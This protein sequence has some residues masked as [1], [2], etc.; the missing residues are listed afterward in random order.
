MIDKGP[1]LGRSMATGRPQQPE[2]AAMFE[3]LIQHP[4]QTPMLYGLVDHVVRQ[5]R[6]A[7]SFLHHMIEGLDGSAD[8]R[9]AQVQFC[10]PRDMTQRPRLQL[11]GGAE[12]VPQAGVMIQVLGPTGVPCWSK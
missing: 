6:N 10:R 1:Q 7:Q 9:C 5:A 8:Q 11:T 3:V 2:T 12:F 4:S